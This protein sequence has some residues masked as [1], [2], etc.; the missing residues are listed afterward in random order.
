MIDHDGVEV[1]TLYEAQGISSRRTGDRR[2]GTSLVKGILELEHEEID[3]AVD[4]Q[5]RPVME[6]AA[7]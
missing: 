3:L 4:D 5:D 1:E 7:Q 6:F 2:V